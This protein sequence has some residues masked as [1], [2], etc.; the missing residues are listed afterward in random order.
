VDGGDRRDYIRDLAILII[1]AAAAID[2]TRHSQQLTK[3]LCPMNYNF[4]LFV[5][6][7]AKNWTFVKVKFS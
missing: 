6:H 2:S 5:Y 1:P 4:E 7:K 3:Q